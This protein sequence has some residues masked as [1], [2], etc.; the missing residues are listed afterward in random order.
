MN[1][2]LIGSGNM[3]SALATQLSKAGHAVAITGR[4]A[5]KAK[6]LARAAGAVFKD[7]SAAE[8]ADVVFVA[9]A[10]PDAV[11]ALQSAGDLNGKVIVDITNPL[12]A[13]YMG[14]TIG[15][16]TSAAE[17]IQN[18]FPAAKVVKAFNTV[19]AQVIAG[20]PQ[21]AGATVPV[22]F[23]GDDAVAKETVKSLIQSMGFAAVDAGGLRNSRYLEPLAGLNIYFGYGAG[24]GTSIAPAFIGFQ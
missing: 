2:T 3:A 14:L 9:T 19:F 16:S 10:Y 11:A 5:D 7:K 20:G 12:K 23:A 24:R 17:E 8:G 22:Y 21:L 1:V 13:D 15:H 6:E 18:A 4:N